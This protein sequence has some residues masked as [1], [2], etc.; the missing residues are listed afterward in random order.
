MS[1]HDFT[2][3]GMAWCDSM[4]ARYRRTL[5]GTEAERDQA[6]EAVGELSSKTDSLEGQLERLGNLLKQAQDRTAEKAKQ[7][8]D[9][10]VTPLYCMFLARRF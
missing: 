4:F 10:E 5:S 7:L 2:L 3:Y 8:M 9:A 1:Y 6:L